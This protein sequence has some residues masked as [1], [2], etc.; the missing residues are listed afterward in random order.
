MFRRLALRSNHRPQAAEIP[1]QAKA[2]AL[3]GYAEV[4]RFLGLSPYAMLRGARIDPVLLDEHDRLFPTD[5]LVTLLEESARRSGCASFGLLMAQSR[6]VSSIGPL[7]LLLEHKAT[8][9]EVAEAVVRYQALLGDGLNLEVE[10]VSDFWIIRIHLVTSVPGYQAIELAAGLFYKA[11]V[12]LTGGRW[13][14]ESAHF[15]HEAP[16]DLSLYRRMFVCPIVFACDFNGFVSTREAFEAPVPTQEPEMARYAEEY[17]LLLLAEMKDGTVAGRTRRTLHL[18]IPSGRGSLRQAAST[19]GMHP[20]AL[21]RLLRVEGTTFADLLNQ[22][23]R[24]LAL[25]YL[26]GSAHSLTEIAQLTG[27]SSLSAFTRWFAAE[28]GI[29]P[30][31]WRRETHGLPSSLAA[32]LQLDLPIE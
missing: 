5:R 22:V 11:L 2:I 20:R 28:F 14:A 30:S 25:R 4:A 3:T 18:T 21:Q 6:A 17:L 15:M 24:E 29:A 1:A 8:A 12:T 10:P 31:A 23:R 27:Y 7:S 13:Q 9:R 19:I 26:S 16:D 32:K